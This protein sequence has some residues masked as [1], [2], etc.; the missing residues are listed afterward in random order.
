[1]RPSQ[2]TQAQSISDSLLSGVVACIQK[3]ILKLRSL[4]RKYWGCKAYEVP[5]QKC[6]R[7]TKCAALSG[8]QRV[9]EVE[10]HLS[11]SHRLI[12]SAGRRYSMVPIAVVW[13]SIG[14]SSQ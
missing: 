11:V 10:L 4:W 12:D 6:R 5:G 7:K 8:P 9:S 3:A 13:S 2:L 14:K 1:M